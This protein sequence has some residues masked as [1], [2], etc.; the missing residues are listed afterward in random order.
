M[1]QTSRRHAL[2]VGA[3]AGISAI[4]L[5][6]CVGPAQDEGEAPAASAS[7][8]VDTRTRVVLLG[9]LG[10]PKILGDER[11]GISSALYHKGE[12]YVID[13]GRGAFSQLSKA[14]LMPTTEGKSLSVL[15]NV[16]GVFFTHLHSDHTVDW[17]MMYVTASAN[18]GSVTDPIQVFG[19]GDRGS[20]PRI[21]PEGAKERKLVAEDDPTLGVSAMTKKLDEAFAQDLNDRVQDSNAP[22][23]EHDVRRTRY[24]PGGDL[25]RG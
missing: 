10:G 19:P 6:A 15:D 11:L 3:L 17:P 2:Q 1:H 13:L 16:R 23:P 21:S 12:V 14:D 18:G 8:G 9:T 20:L 22:P 5:S 25:G 24:R 7:N 4:G